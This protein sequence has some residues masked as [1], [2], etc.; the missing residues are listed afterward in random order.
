VG[1]IIALLIGL[2]AAFLMEQ[3]LGHVETAAELE[4]ILGAPTLGV[5]PRAA[6]LRRGSAR[7]A[8][9]EVPSGPTA[10]AYRGLRT[11]ILA[12]SQRLGVKSLLVTSA[13][14]GEGKSTI[15]ANLSV[16]LAQAGRSVVLISGDL[17][18]PSLHMLFGV[19]NER[20]LT[21]VL[22]ELVSLEEALTDTDTEGLKLLP[23][24]PLTELDGSALL[25]SYGMRNVLERCRNADFVVIDGPP[26]SVAADSL[27]L[28][29]LVDGIL[30][31]VDAKKSTR[32]A[33]LRTQRQLGPLDARVLGGVVNRVRRAVPTYI[34]KSQ[35]VPT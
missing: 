17:H 32:A 7:P 35:V 30:L 34:G 21:Q 13:G 18:R 27:S 15:A 22:G 26:I 33:V 28:G 10:E 29:Q 5:I 20:G 19:S 24:G 8:M 3:L 16:A 14:I 12:V 25:Q 4:N 1:G 11:N 9:I 2:G 31:V 6:S 23:S